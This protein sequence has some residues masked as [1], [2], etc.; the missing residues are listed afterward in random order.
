MWMKLIGSALVIAACAGLGAD[1][2]RTF[3]KRLK[4]LEKLKLMVTHLKGEILYAN[5]PLPEAFER[6][7]RRSPGP[8]GT[9]FTEVAGELKKETGE[10]F[11]T[12]WRQKTEEFLKNSVLKGKERE[13]LLQFGEHLGYLDR[14]MQEKTILFYIE[15]LEQSI[16]SL[17]RQEPEKCRLFLSLGVLSGLFLAVVML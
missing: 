16:T 3:R 14:E 13:Q 12:I 6:T 7:G 1:A 15:D 17:R 10:R 9:L 2:A 11:E 5:A 8:A 4:L